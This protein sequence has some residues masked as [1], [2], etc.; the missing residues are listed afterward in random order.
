VKK[1]EGKE[2]RFQFEDLDEMKAAVTVLQTLLGERL[3]LKVRW[4]D[5][6]GEY[7]KAA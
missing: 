7:V 2:L 3:R 1:R 4:D 5:R 6:K